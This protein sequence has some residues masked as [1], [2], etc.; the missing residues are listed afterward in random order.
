VIQAESSASAHAPARIDVIF[1]A[2]SDPTR[3]Q[4][5]EQLSRG[6]SSVSTL[7]AD[8]S[9]ALPSFVEHL[10]V[11]EVAGLVRSK[12]VGRVRTLELATETLGIAQTWL[13]RQR[14]IWEARLDRLD[15]HLLAM[16]KE[17][18]K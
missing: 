17:R 4:V 2:L 3:R 5:I 11:L 14:A 1:R 12:K 10:K 7:A 8:H 6:A 18:S 16:K 13:D 9:M 15:A